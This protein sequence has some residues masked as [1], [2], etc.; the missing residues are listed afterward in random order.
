MRKKTRSIYILGPIYLSGESYIPFYKTLGRF[1]KGYFDTV[2]CTYPDF[3]KTP[4]NPQVF[5]RRTLMVV[6]NSSLLLAEVSK[7]SHGVG[8]ELQMAKERN[9][10][11]LAAVRKEVNISKSTMVQ[12]LPN[13]AGIFSY[14]DLPELEKKLEI[15]FEQ[16]GYRK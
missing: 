12:G 14:A 15:F 11:I 9:I 16:H 5:Y 3:W 4:K 2:V 8:I 10:P 1:C 6:H 7:P 13:L